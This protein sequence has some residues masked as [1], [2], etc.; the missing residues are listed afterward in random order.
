MNE[1]LLQKLIASGLNVGLSTIIATNAKAELSDIELETITK[2]IMDGMT[3]ANQSEIDRRVTQA[4]KTGIENYEKKH[5]LKEGK[6]IE[7]EKIIDPVKPVIPSNTN[8]SENPQLKALMDIINKQNE[9]IAKLHESFDGLQKEKSK[10]ERQLKIKKLLNDAKI[11]EILQ[12]H[13]IVAE[14][15]TDDELLTEVNSYKQGLADAGLAGLIIP[16][17]GEQKD[18]SIV[19]AEQAAKSRN[20]ATNSTGIVPGKKI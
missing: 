19:T 11:P 7:P 3:A 9:S 8:E 18:G 1:K 16:G 20:D 6:F 4:V 14:N 10:E 13:F 5:N 12:K 15:A 17:K 2:S